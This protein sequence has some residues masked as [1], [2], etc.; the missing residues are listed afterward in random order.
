MAQ[1]TDNPG[2]AQF[3]SDVKTITKEN[4]T[5]PR[6]PIPSGAYVV[7]SAREEVL[8]AYL[9]TCLGV[10]LW[11]PE[12]KVGGLIHLLLPEPSSAAKPWEPAAYASTGM[13]LFLKS[14]LEEGASQERLLACMA[15]GALV[16]PVSDL[17]LDLNIGG[18]TAE[19]VET[20]LSQQHI[21]LQKMETGGF[22]TCRLSL[23]LRN[24][25]S[26][27]DPLGPFLD[28]IG[29]GIIRKP[30]PKDIARSMERVR[31]IPQI[32]LKITRMVRD[33][34]YSF[35][36]VAKE[37]RQDQ[38]L[39][40]KVIRLCRSALFGQKKAVDSIDRALSMLGEKRF[41]QLV[42]SASL[43]DFYPSQTSGYSLC[44]GGLFKHALGMA[45]VCEG[46]AE[47]TKKAPSDTAYT[48]GLLHDIGKAVLD[49]HVANAFGLFYRRVQTE[50][51]NITA[52]EKELLG[53]THTEVGGM[54]AERW[55]LPESL[56][57]VIL[58]H[59]QPEQAKVNSELVHLVYLAELILSRFMVGQE[60]ESIGTQGLSV[61]LRKLGIESSQFPAIVD[62]TRRIIVN[63]EPVP[64]H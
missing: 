15:G 17:D 37:I 27:I 12:A 13:P 56:T 59:H 46:L 16:G 32:A 55:S 35:Q 20:F 4:P 48:A 29:K 9:G 26:R 36:D 45:I 63:D 34:E 54:L 5:V 57:D 40:A 38:I 47:S 52:A 11:D 41:L 6:R 31:P 60:M 43:E 7:A 14:L 64:P 30:S 44:K 8:E 18:R 42:V 1:L 21:P 19:A 22:F 62:G 3:L 23:D 28:G 24:M 51:V 49:Q 39:S 10:T 25:E 50:G 53:T 61:R 2:L 33:G 58:H